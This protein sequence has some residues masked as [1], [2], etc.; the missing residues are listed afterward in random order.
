MKKNLLISFLIFTILTFFSCDIIENRF[1]YIK[2]NSKYAISC[3]IT[4]R[5]FNLVKKSDYMKGDRFLAIGIKANRESSL[6]PRKSSWERFIEK[7][8]DPKLHFYVVSQ[9]NIYKYGV[10]TIPYLNEICILKRKILP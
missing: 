5:D 2:N 6:S 7:C 10:D 4:N 3:F 8:E 9:N 1:L